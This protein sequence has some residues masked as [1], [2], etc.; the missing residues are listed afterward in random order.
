MC[1]Q[2]QDVRLF[3]CLFILTFTEKKKEKTLYT[4]LDENQQF[5]VSQRRSLLCKIKWKKNSPIPNT[6]F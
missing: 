6:G 4:N 5:V 1:I 2:K 3:L